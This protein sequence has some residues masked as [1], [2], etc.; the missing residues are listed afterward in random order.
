LNLFFDVIAP[1]YDRLM[2]QP[3]AGPLAKALNL[4]S[5]GLL[6]DVGGGTGRVSRLLASWVGGVAVCDASRRMLARARSTGL[7][8]V[9]GSAEGLPFREGAFARVLVV[10]ALHHFRRQRDALS[11]LVRVLAPGGRLLVS[12]PDIAHA[13]VRLISLAERLAL[14]DS[15]FLPPAEVAAALAAQGLVVRIERNGITAWIIADKAE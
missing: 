9:Q 3:D 5:D 14:M 10:D 13:E 4:P 11:E 15:H 8:A 12:E 2:G 1:L 6:L 7:N